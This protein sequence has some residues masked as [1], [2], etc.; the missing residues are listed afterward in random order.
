VE[1]ASAFFLDEI[2]EAVE[3]SEPSIFADVKTFPLLAERHSSRR[4]ITRIQRS[5]LFLRIKDE[6][7]LLRSYSVIRL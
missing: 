2:F 3:M 5:S 7:L 1:I 4:K 6:D